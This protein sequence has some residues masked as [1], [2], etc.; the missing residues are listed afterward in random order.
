MPTTQRQ[1]E[2]LFD[3]LTQQKSRRLEQPIHRISRHPILAGQRV[4]VGVDRNARPAV[5]ER[6]GDNLDPPGV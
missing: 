6:L 4:H 1:P 3:V 5:P 2:L